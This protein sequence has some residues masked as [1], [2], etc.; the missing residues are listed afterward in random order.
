MQQS[1]AETF[2]LHWTELVGRQDVEGVLALYAEDAVLVPT[3]SNRLLTTPERIREY[4]VTLCSRERLG[5]ELHTRPRIVTPVS[6]HVCALGGIYRW[7]F[8]VDEELLAF[9][10]RFSFLLDFARAAPIL[11]HHSSQIPRSL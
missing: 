10:A 2:L 1:K 4:F 9:E 8:A 3:F 7:Q 5:L 11:H 6:E